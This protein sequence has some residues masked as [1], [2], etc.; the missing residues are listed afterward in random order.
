MVVVIQYLRGLA[1]L[2]V[3]Y[4]HLDTQI[5]RLLVD[6][7]LPYASIGNWGV[8]IFFVISGFIMYVAAIEIDSR[9]GEFL[10]R[11]AIR[12]VPL[13]WALTA[14]I[15]AI[16]VVA[17]SLLSSTRLDA[18]HVLASLLF[19]P[20]PNPAFDGHWPVLIPGWTLNYE[21]YF[22]A[23]VALGLLAPRRYRVFLTSAIVLGV[24][25]T[26]QGA[27]AAGPVAFYGNDIVIEFLLGLIA[28]YL[29]TRARPLGVP[30]GLALIGLSVCSVIAMADLAPVPRSVAS[31]IP[32]LMLVLGSLQLETLARRS[33]FRPALFLGD[34]SYSLYL[35]HVIA[36]P[37]VTA[38]FIRLDARY[39]LDT[40]AAYPLVAALWALLVAALVYLAIEKPLTRRLRV[41]AGER[42]APVRAPT[43]YPGR[44]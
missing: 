44:S 17:P 38:I 40:A 12:I 43:L 36:L 32:A 28:G 34:I 5:L 23:A 9:P 29:F 8:D 30:I 25:V 6:D 11:R 37:M 7:G 4:T 26:V 3:V 15:V 42:P 33:P 24:L 21:M 14:L 18:S 2:L 35:T 16:A 13:Y 10:L 20:W 41:A 1:A 22:Y 19:L 31:G 39:G 27:Q